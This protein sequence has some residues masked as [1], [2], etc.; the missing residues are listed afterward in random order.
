MLVRGRYGTSDWLISAPYDLSAGGYQLDFNISLTVWN[1]TN[2][3][4]LG[5]DD[6]VV[7]LISEDAGAT[8]TTLLTWDNTS[9]VSNT[10]EGVSVDLTPYTNAYTQFAFY[11]TEGTVDDPEDM[12]FH[13]DDFCVATPPDCPAPTFLT[14]S[15]ESSV[16]A[17]LAWTEN[18][19]A[20]IYDLEIVTTGTAPTGT[21]TVMGVANP[22]TWT[23]GA[24]ETTYDYYV[25]ADCGGTTGASDWVGPVSFTTLEACPAPSDLNAA[26]SDV[27]ATLTW[28]E[29]GI[30]TV[31]DIEFGASGF[32]PT[33][34]PTSAG[35][36][37]P[38]VEMG[39][40]AET[41]YE[42]Y[43]RSD[44][45]MVD[46]VSTWAGPFAFS[47]RCAATVPSAC[48]DF[49]GYGFGVPP[50]CWEEAADGTPTTGPIGIGSGV[51][52]GEAFGNNGTDTGARINLFT[53]GY[54]DWLISEPYDLSA[55]SMMLDF[56]IALTEY[57]STAAGNLGSDD[58]I[59]LLISEDAGLTW[60]ALMTWDASSTISNLGEPI[61]I[62][63]AAY[64]NAYTLFAFYGTDGTVNDPEDVEFYADN[65]CVNA[66]ITC[67]DPTMPM[68]ANITDSGADLSWTENGM[69]TA[70]D[71]E[72]VPLGAVPTGT[73]TDAAV[74]SNPYT[75]TGGAA[76]TSYDFYVR[77]NCGAMETSMW[78][79]P[80]SFTTIC[81]PSL[82]LTGPNSGDGSDASN[83]AD[84][85]SSGNITS[86]QTITTGATID[87]DSATDIDLINNFEVEAGA[88]FEA[89]IDGCNNG[90]GGSNFQGN[91]ETNESNN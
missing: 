10:G 44:C 34:T 85:E 91:T 30:A 3:G 88:T 32:T 89:F 36:M 83:V 42:Y 2:A 31:W 63:L 14:A 55:G 78:V 77:A 51:W 46:G 87:Y 33:G 5:S 81:P 65:F 13:V 12:E 62:D 6:Q 19:M 45:G 9:S 18:G 17:D 58:E 64:T 39:L 74:A 24:S 66:P 35:V 53:T 48:Q 4:N 75:W 61:N 73:P 60:T 23:G 29:N 49:T 27:M 21:P 82:I 47:T 90:A 26:A 43:V 84:N 80:M 52:A 22:Y 72:I 8:W 76:Q 16:G 56:D 38:H 59:Q 70:W 41:A 54:S 79:G 7:L 71:L 50:T 68:V 86:N 28:T 69:A 11:A 15:N 37:N 40:T 57:N 20:T 1:S 25:R 67:L